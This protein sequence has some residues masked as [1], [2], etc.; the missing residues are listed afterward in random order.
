MTYQLRGIKRK[1]HTSFVF[2][3]EL[4]RADEMAQWVKMFVVPLTDD[5]I[6]LIERALT[7]QNCP[8][9]SMHIPWYILVPITMT[10]KNVKG[11]QYG[12]VGK[13]AYLT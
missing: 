5:V 9:T 3:K 13:G 10:F 8:W 4:S 12:S 1:L 7:I 2:P 11:L 6:S